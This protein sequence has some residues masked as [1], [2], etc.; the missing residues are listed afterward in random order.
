ME[1]NQMTIFQASILIT[2]SGILYGFLG[3][4]GVN[5]MSEN[6][7]VPNML[8]WRFL[9]AG[10]WMA[11][12]VIKKHAK[13]NIF[14]QIDKRTL[15]LT[16]ILGAVG[17]AGS[18]ELYFVAIHYTG[19][20]LAMVIFFTYPIMIAI[21]SW[22]FYRQP[23]SI[24]TIVTFIM[25]TIGLFFLSDSLTHP[26]S[27]L[28]ICLALIGAVCY[29]LY[30]FG[31]KR[32]S[33]AKVDSN[34]LTMMVCFSCAFIFISILLFTHQFILPNT[35]RA[36]LYLI[37]LGILATALPIQLMLEGLK[38]VSS[39]RASLISVLEPLVTIIV[40]ITL[41][42]ESISQIQ[43]IGVIIVLSSTIIVQFQKE[44]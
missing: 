42:G 41:L 26:L 31:S 18:S 33:S 34:V 12:W 30:L 22:L 20:G 28:G 13:N 15:F 1:N 35:M 7:S 2:L 19:T 21:L 36:W 4:L 3:Y 23:L 9:L 39:M 16:F 37:A 25:M 6:I 5:V 44:L 10:L 27:I 40:G 32:F 29:A 17:Y 38:Y 11:L 14:S 24:T 8:F 43:I